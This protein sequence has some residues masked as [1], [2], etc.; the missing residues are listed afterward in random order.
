L[1]FSMSRKGFR[2]ILSAAG[3]VTALALAGPIASAGACKG[4]GLGPSQLSAAQAQ[5]TIICLMNQRRKHFHAPKLH[6]NGQLA[7]AAAEHS[8]SMNQE[9]YFSHDSSSDGDPVSRITST[10]YM[11][12]ATSWGVGENLVWGNGS[13]ATPQQAVA[14]WMNSPEHRTIM[15][16]R[17]FREV[18][19]GFVVGSPTGGDEGNSAIYTADFGFRH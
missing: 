15:L 2:K 18:G 19:I 12:H 8:S 11:S 9:N 1:L 7:A 3:L 6:G 17:S 4:A 16:S 14:S 13:L 10:G 5:S